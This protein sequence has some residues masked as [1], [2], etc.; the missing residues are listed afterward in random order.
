MT[1]KETKSK[2][3]KKEEQ[4]IVFWGFWGLRH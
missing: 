2:S 1:E 4:R 3:E